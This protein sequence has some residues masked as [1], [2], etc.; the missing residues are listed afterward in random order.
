MNKL[1]KILKR[2]FRII[3][4]KKG[5][6]GKYSKGN[7]FANNVYMVE[8]AVIGKYNYIGPY[9]M[10]NNTVIGNYCSI[11][12]SV[13]LGQGQHSINFIT[14]YQKISSDLIG[15]SLTESPTVIGNDVWCGANVVIMQG[16]KIGDGVVI[17]ANAVVTKDIPDYAIAV[18]IPAKIIKYRFNEKEIKLIKKSRWFD[19]DLK[20]AK[21]VIN[22]INF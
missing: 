16:V 7:K 21:K 5:I 19:Y 10:I 18:G 9:T 22:E 3:I 12:P 20:E 17:G 15:H 13:K 4:G 6:Y 11:G 14:T 8:A 1:K 2:L